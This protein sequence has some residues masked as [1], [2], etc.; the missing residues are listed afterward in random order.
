MR[1]QIHPTKVIRLVAFGI[2]LLSGLNSLAQ[3]EEEYERIIYFDANY[4]VNQNCS[5]R[6]TERITVYCNQQ[7][8]KRGIYRDIPLNYEYQGGRTDVD[9][10][11]IS[12]TRNGKAENSHTENR[13]NGIRTYFG[14][15]DTYLS[16]GKHTYE[17]TYEVNHVLRLLDKT[18]ELYW[19]TNGNGWI[20]TVDSLRATVQLPAGIPFKQFTAYTGGAGSSGKNFSVVQT[21]DNELVYK[22]TKPLMWKEGLTFAASWDKNQLT[23][24]SALD[25]FLYWVKS[26][27]LW[28]LLIVMI[29]F[30]VSRSLL[31]WFRYG[32]DP[33]PGTIMP[34]YEAPEGFSPADVYAVMNRGLVTSNAFTGQIASL[35]AK[36]W[37]KIKQEDVNG[38]PKYTFTQL[39]N[40]PKELT[41]A[42][43]EL[44]DTL[45]SG[46][47]TFTFYQNT[48]N[49]TLKSGMDHL[50]HYISKEHGEKYRKGNVNI[51][52]SQH[53]FLLGFLILGFA[54]KFLFGG[55]FWII[56]AIA[57]VGIIINLVFAYLLEQP[58]TEGRKIMDHILGL[59]LYIQYADQKRIQFNNPP[60]L[61]FET[62]E[63]L[64]P[65]AIV[66]NLAK[67]WQGQFNSAELQT[68]FGMA[69]Y[70]YAGMAMGGFS[71]F[72]SSTF[73]SAISS[74]SV[75][76]SA[77]GGSSGSSY[78]GGGGFSGGGGGGGGGG[79]W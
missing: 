11:F 39:E 15:E 55:S 77:S 51:S 56:G 43:K 14:S 50:Q 37:I 29:I 27:A 34:Q 23:Y 2:F 72:N 9:F 42:E 67:E 70:W 78:S 68:R 79:G 1:F 21:H 3:N 69:G 7:E 61:N 75:P 35:G 13:S 47:K 73:S 58:T 65:F 63:R 66:L 52:G 4:R 53:L 36:G 64:L 74:A 40:S 45:F 10:E 48:Y 76:P 22:T 26:H 18:D 12:L 28:V 32:R 30:Q 6:I 57:L 60:D 46:K 71:H 33:E 17:F 49:A 54:L 59:K 44:Y 62:F 31:L 38:A 19:N 16:I 41:S 25:N 20:F 24:P 8:I 5:M